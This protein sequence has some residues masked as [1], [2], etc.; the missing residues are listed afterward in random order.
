VL[1]HLGVDVSEPERFTASVPCDNVAAMPTAPLTDTERK[2]ETAIR[3]LLALSL[4]DVAMT[5]ALAPV[6]GAIRSKYPSVNA[7]PEDPPTA[8]HNP[9]TS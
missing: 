1:R 3:A 2:A 5:E 8:T 6:I 7:G 4:A 9:P